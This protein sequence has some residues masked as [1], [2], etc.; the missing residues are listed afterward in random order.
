MFDY[1]TDQNEAMDSLS[2]ILTTVHGILQESVAHYFSDAY[3]D[4]ARV[5]HDNR[6]VANCIY[7][8]AEKRMMAAAEVVDGVVPIRLRG[9][10]VLNY[11]DKVLTRFKKVNGNGR[12]S[13]YLTKQQLAYDDQL[14]LPGIPDAARRLTV[15]YELDAEGL[16][17]KQIMITRPMGRS[18]LWT[19]QVT[20]DSDIAR[21]E[22]ITPQKFSGMGA[23]DFSEDTVRRRRGG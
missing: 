8:H 23:S 16:G 2:P 13:N 4:A 21:W 20:V 18:I 3:T 9:L 12:H 7:S 5:D 15:G 10:V 11:R 1:E 14:T 22:D 17:L 6:A 19:A